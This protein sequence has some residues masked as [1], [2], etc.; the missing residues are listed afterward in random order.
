MPLIWKRNGD[1]KHEKY[2]VG[3]AA[4]GCIAGN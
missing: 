4:D 1:G 3:V 2:T